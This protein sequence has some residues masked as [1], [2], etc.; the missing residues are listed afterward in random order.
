MKTHK[1]LK[2]TSQPEQLTSLIKKLQDATFEGFSYD[3]EKTNEYAKIIF[4][5]NNQVLSFISP[6]IRGA[7]AYV[8]LL[9]DN[10]ELTIT[11]I[12]P[13]K[14]GKLS[15][16]QYN[17]I[18]DKFFEAVLKPNVETQHHVKISSEDKTI[19][20]YAGVEVA[21]TLN[22]W[23]RLANKSTLNTDSFDFERWAEFLITAHKE[24]SELTTIQLGKYLMEEIMVPDDELVEQITLDYEHG[25]SLL[26]E[27]DKHR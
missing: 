27:Y 19:E 20:D 10:N 7:I 13:N 18:L 11:N 21:K 15:I 4:K 8:W 5:E 14:S 25:R 23:I 22:S 17:S 2:I 16:E 9:L 3:S 24:Q 26:K 12:T 1:S 6:E